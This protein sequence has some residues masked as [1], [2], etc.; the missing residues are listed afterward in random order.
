[1]VPHLVN[2]SNKFNHH[3]IIS[4]VLVYQGCI[5]FATR[6]LRP[7]LLARRNLTQVQQWETLQRLINKSTRETC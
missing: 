3:S 4:S 6:R 5:D 7:R 1:M 2:K